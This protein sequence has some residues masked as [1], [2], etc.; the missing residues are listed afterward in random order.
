M[1]ELNHWI[2]GKEVKG[3]S[4]RFS[5]VYNPAT[6]ERLWQVYHD[7]MNASAR[8]QYGNGLVFVTNG[9]GAMIAV[10][11]D[12]NTHSRIPLIL[13]LPLKYKSLGL[14]GNQDFLVRTTSY[15]TIPPPMVGTLSPASGMTLSQRVTAIARDISTARC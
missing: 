15:G 4:G 12:G 5:D 14:A 6:G 9:M 11:P 1:Q 3:T 2:D 7:G 13:F 10:R 8:P